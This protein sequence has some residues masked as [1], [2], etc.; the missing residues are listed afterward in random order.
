MKTPLLYG[1]LLALVGALL[2]YGM[3]FAGYHDTAE[4]MQSVQWIQICIGIIATVVLMAL[5][6]RERRTEYPTEQT[7]GYG[8]AFGTAVLTGLVSVVLGG[9]L[10]YIYFAFV[11]PQ[12][13]EIVYQA[14]VLKMEQKGIPSSQIDAASGMM[15]K[16]TSPAVMIIFQVIIGCIFSALFAL[17][18]AIFFR[19]RDTPVPADLESTPP[20]V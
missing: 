5:A 20:V 14:Q 7:W 12:F 8:S 16:F 6:I 1:S 19:N 18:I 2:T 9:I 17:I 3:Y 11:N 10:S 15:R 4:K 13:S